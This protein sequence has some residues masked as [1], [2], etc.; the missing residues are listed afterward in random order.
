MSLKASISG[1]RGIVG[2]S[3]TPQVITDYVSAFLSI[4]PDGPILI[5]RDSRVTGPMILDLVK[6]VITFSGRDV[7]DMGII[8]T[9]VV[10]FGVQKNDFAGG[11]VI[12]ASHNPQQWN[13]LKFVNADG[14]FLSPAQFRQMSQA[15]QDKKFQYADYTHIGHCSIDTQIAQTHLDTIVKAVDTN[16]IRN[17]KITVALDTVNGAGGEHTLR[18]LEKFGCNVVSINTEPTGLFAHTPEPTP[19]N[20]TQLSD[21]IKSN[22]V[23]V[24]FALDPDGDRLV[25]ADGSGTIICEELTL[26]LC[27]Q[28]YL[29][30]HKKSDVVI[31]LSSSRITIDIADKFGSK[32]YKEPTGEI[33][34]TEKM[35]AIGASIGGEG[36]GGIIVTAI[37]KCRDAS[38]GIAFILEMLTQTDKTLAEIVAE[39]PQYQLIKKKFDITELDLSAAEKQLRTLYPNAEFD[40][41][42]GIRVDFPDKWLLVRKS[43]TETIVR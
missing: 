23:D 39:L 28:Q 14:K 21:L 1:V 19:A 8:P 12:T 22:K 20:L 36:N 43:N 7:T 11:I 31:N 42:D 10:L 27:V 16:A 6:S 38:V 5:G 15:Y 26:A 40:C 32:V 41:R 33:N 35:E 9:P 4:L 18:L 37:N 29:A 13:A 3:L 24:G 25:I 2:E 34:V 17:K 30:H